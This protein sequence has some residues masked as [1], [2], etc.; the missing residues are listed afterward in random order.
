VSAGTQ[1]APF[2]R[3]DVVTRDAAAVIR[4]LAITLDRPAAEHVVLLLD[5]CR[6]ARRLELAGSGIATRR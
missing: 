1:R 6:E 3:V 2:G 5:G 4:E